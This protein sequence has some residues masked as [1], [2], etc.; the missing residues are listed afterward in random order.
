MGLLWRTELRQSL[1]CELRRFGGG[2]SGHRG[3]YDCNGSKSKTES[4]IKTHRND[5]QCPARTKLDTYGLTK[6]ISV[7]GDLYNPYPSVTF[8][9]RAPMRAQIKSRAIVVRL[10]PC[11]AFGDAMQKLLVA[12]LWRI[13]KFSFLTSDT[14]LSCPFQ[15]HSRIMCMCCVGDDIV[16]LGTLSWGLNAYSSST[17]FEMCDIHFPRVCF[18]VVFFQDVNCPVLFVAF[19][20]YWCLFRP[21]ATVS[22]ISLME[23]CMCHCCWGGPPPPH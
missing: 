18:V 6:N 5:R 7:L 9:D 13:A 14:F 3:L 16:L 19:W 22:Q 21:S 2:W 17:R 23:S 10:Q 11:S 4:Y 15:I 20:I 1:L 8:S 12:G